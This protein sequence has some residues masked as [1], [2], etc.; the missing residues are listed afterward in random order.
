MGT[1]TNED[2]LPSP[3]ELEIEELPVSGVPLKAA[4]YHLGLFCDNESKVRPVLNF[5]AT[6]ALV[7]VY[8]NQKGNYGLPIN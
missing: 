1:Y 7:Q 5:L 6:R 8:I 4:G 2:Y 3:E